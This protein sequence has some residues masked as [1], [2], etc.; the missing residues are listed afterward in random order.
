MLR[1]TATFA[2]SAALATSAPEALVPARRRL[3][4]K[5]LATTLAAVGGLSLIAG[6]AEAAAPSREKI[7]AAV[8]A[9]LGGKACN[10]GYFNS[11]G[12]AWCA[13]FA[14]WGWAE[15]GVTDRKGLDAWAQSFK[16]YGTDRDLYHARNSGYKPQPGDA[17][18]FDW[19]HNS[20]DGHPI[21]H[22]A[23]VT[24]V[25]KTQVNT[26]G[27]NQTSQ[28]K[29]SRSS[30]SRSNS[31]IIGYVTPAGLGGGTS[32]P[33]PVQPDD[34]AMIRHSVTGDSF[35]DLVTRHTDGSLLLYA[36][37]FVR[38][39]GVPYSSASSR[40]I[41]QGWNAFDKI[42]NA[43]VTGDGYSDLVARKPDGTLWLYSNNI[44]RDNGVPY[45]SASSRQIGQGWNAFDTIIGADVTGD[46]YTDLVGRKPDGTLWLYSN[47][48]ERDNGT[49]FSSASARQI[50]NGWGAFD[51]ITG[52]DVTGDGYTDLIVRKAD[53]TLWLFSN[54][55][56]RDNG[57][58]YSSA[59]SRQ[60]GS[61]WS[62]IDVIAADVTGDGYTDLVGRK[63]DGTLWLYPNNIERDNGTPYSSADARQIGS[64]WNNFNAI[65]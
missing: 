45:S 36:N 58:P 64:G 46:G 21:D 43:D 28:S 6:P 54:N 62:T 7:V 50:G 30:Y 16:T 27:G 44:E 17:I 38:D 59:S 19:D 56:I 57:T 24:S 39:E 10:P 33:D 1:H 5:L 23:I 52:S 55:I 25:T 14:R 60:I 61:G 47:N 40:P 35:A 12:I 41:G 29:V 4:R 37:N 48:I 49:P 53:G 65:I 2:D 31:D 13:E 26:I 51:S 32:E 18:V 15:G 22:V 9:E 42:V 3:G 63:A 20:G 11:C 34:E 8:K